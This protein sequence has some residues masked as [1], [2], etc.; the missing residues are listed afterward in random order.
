MNERFTLLDK[1]LCF[2]SKDS[3]NCFSL[4]MFNLAAVSKSLLLFI[5]VKGARAEVQEFLREILVPHF[6]TINTRWMCC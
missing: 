1:S 2:L 3:L 5:A 4:M 6:N